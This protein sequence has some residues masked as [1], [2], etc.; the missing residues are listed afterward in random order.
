MVYYLAIFERPDPIDHDGRITHRI[1]KLK[2]D[3]L[4]KEETIMIQYDADVFRVDNKKVI[5]VT[6]PMVTIL[7]CD[8]YR[9]RN[10]TTS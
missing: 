6:T 9:Q 4:C 5:S 8:G 7:I 10:L 2:F 3:I 1:S